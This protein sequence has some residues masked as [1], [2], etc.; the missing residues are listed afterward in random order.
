MPGT[1]FGLGFALKERVEADDPEGMLGEYH[2]GGM[3]GT[4]SWMAPKANLTGMCMTQLMPG[5]WHP[6]SHEFKASAYA[7]GPKAS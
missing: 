5:F 4:H 2:W 7:T 3:A 1:T 6:F